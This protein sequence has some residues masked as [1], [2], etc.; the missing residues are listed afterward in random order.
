GTVNPVASLSPKRLIKAALA[1][2]GYEIRAIPTVPRDVHE[3]AAFAKIGD[4]I[5]RRHRAQ[6]REDVAALRAKYARPLYGLVNTWDLLERLAG[7]GRPPRRQPL[8]R[9][10]AAPHAPGAGGDGAGSHRG[11][12]APFRRDAPRRGQALAPRR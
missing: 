11:S 9:E 7:C 8:R 6:T 2:R 10:P 12:G 1:R 5:Q 3:R 4:E